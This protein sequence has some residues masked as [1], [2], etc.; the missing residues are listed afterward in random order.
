MTLGVAL[1]FLCPTTASAAESVPRHDGQALADPQV[2]AIIGTGSGVSLN[3]DQAKRIAAVI[4][5][6]GK[7]DPVEIDLIDEI[8]AEN[9][10]AINIRPL[11]GDMAPKFIGTLSGA[12]K[13]VFVDLLEGYY[14][15]LY[16]AEDA[17]RG[18]EALVRQSLISPSAYNRVSSFLLP[19]AQAA[20]RESTIANTYKPARELLSG[21]YARHNALPAELQD[22]S[23]WL[24]YRGF[25]G[26]DM[27][28]SDQL[29]DFLYNWVKPQPAP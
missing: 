23:R 11:S 18:W 12:R 3:E 17:V 27:N 9:I 24:M 6:D 22:R 29:P 19:K 26:A 28:L 25:E 15:E 21:W 7:L 14:T 8:I 1:A 20:A 2:L 10:R 13:Q 4:M 16:E 5:A